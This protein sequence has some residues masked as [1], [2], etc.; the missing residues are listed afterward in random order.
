MNPSPDIQ[1]CVE[2]GWSEFS[3]PHSWLSAGWLRSHRPA[4]PPPTPIDK[5]ILAAKAS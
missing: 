2:C 4:P 5:P 1:V 3:I